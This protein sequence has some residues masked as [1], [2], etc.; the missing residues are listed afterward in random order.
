[1]RYVFKILALSSEPSNAISYISKAFG[2]VGEDNATYS[3][4]YN[5]INVLDDI[6][7]LELNVITDVINTDFDETIASID[8]IIYFLN[9]LRKGEADFFE[10]ILPIIYSVKRDI[11]TIIVI[12]DE[13]CFLPVSINT[14]LENIWINYP[15]LEAF[16]NIL[17]SEFQQVLECLC[18]AMITGDTP[19]NIENAWMRFP[20][21]IKLAN[22][23][24]QNQNLFYAAQALKKMAL[25]ANIYEKQEYFI[26]SEQAAY[27][28][29]KLNLFLEAS[30]ILE[31]IDGKKSKDFKKMYADAI[32]REG[33]ILFN[34]NKFE[35]AALQYESAGQWASIEL[36]DKAI[37][38]KS[39]KLAINSWIS[40]CK[41]EKSFLILERLPHEEIKPI[42]TDIVDKIIA[43]AD[44]LMS[45]ENFNSARE[46]LYYSVNTY[47][48][49]GLS[50]TVKKLTQKLTIVLTTI[51]KNSIKNKEIYHAKSIYD[52]IENMWESFKVETIDL[53]SSL[54]VLIKLF[55]DELNFSM[56]TILINKLNSYELKKE[57][58]EYSSKVEDDNKEL[59]KKEVE[60][61][62]QK[63]IEILKEFI[64]AE[65]EIVAEM[66]KE[67]I[68]QA[69]VLV[70]QKDWLQA[71]DHIKTQA[72]F[73]K[74]I[75]KE[76]IENQILTKSLDILLDGKVFDPFFNYYQSL[77]VEMKNNYLTRSYPVIIEKLKDLKDSESYE[78][79]KSVFQN[80]NVIFRDLE[81]YEY[82][83]N[84]SE[85]YVD[86]IKKEIIRIV[87]SEENL[88]GVNKAVDLIKNISQISSSY[89]DN[90][91]I[92]LDEIYG[93]ITEL[94][95]YQIGDL[96]SAYAYNDKIEEK[97]LKAELHK[98]IVDIETSQSAI[99]VAAAKDSLR[100]EILVEKLS[101]IKQKARDAL[102]DKESELKQR[103]GYKRV[104]F[105]EA[106]EFIKN[107]EFEKAVEKYK[108]S[109]TRLNKIKKY[110]LAGVSLAITCLLLM[111]E[112]KLQE[113]VALLKDKDL[114]SSEKSFFDTFP[115]TLIKYIMDIQKLQDDLKL[116]QALS[117]LENLPLF[118]EE[119]EE[120]YD[121]LGKEYQKEDKS[122][123]STKD[124][125]DIEKIIGRINEI[126]RV[127]QKEKSDVSKRKLMKKQY[128]DEALNGLSQK[129]MMNASLAYLNAVPPLADKNLY[130]HAAIGLILGSLALVKEKDVEIS[131]QTFEN[132]LNDLNQDKRDKLKALPEVKLM[133]QAYLALVSKESG[134]IELS[135]N[136]LADKL[137]L[138]D[139]EINF[140]KSFLEEESDEKEQKEALSRRERAELS[141]HV[142]EL[143]QTFGTL[144]QK[145]RDEDS[146][147]FFTKRKAMRR[148]YYDE[149]LNLLN[150]NSFN[151]AG[152]KYLELAT[153]ISKRKDFKTSS[154]LVLL[155]GLSAMKAGIPFTEIESNINGFLDS[156]G[157]NKTV[158][159]D[160]FEIMLILF[161]IDIKMNDLDQFTSKIVKILEILPFFDEEKELIEI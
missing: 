152:E 8:G 161:I 86:V 103:R 88:T 89:L 46:Q 76:E 25:I 14:L 90:A 135:L 34:K 142:V 114:V 52:E 104:Y 127:I 116:N 144:E 146:K 136:H 95:L 24:F 85:L 30:K 45:I 153:T 62:I 122:K 124:I 40:A 118:E 21:F 158:V 137:I 38:N 61:N 130:K 39:F 141:K 105:K 102:H 106:L 111:K 140:L 20:V 31:N 47:Q 128:W 22:N 155:Y 75:G 108:E 93:K 125:V 82:S 15:D 107:G 33:N 151:K 121:Y 41:C 67:K 74:E 134:L 69:D 35:M 6:C 72:E 92:D 109:I 18:I 117:F 28:Y 113:M 99:A 98:K 70:K 66:N 49:E 1:M 5:E 11:P 132:N 68:K 23:Y 17:P 65:Q 156:L 44:Y 148:H 32:I 87:E 36:K 150:N 27:L 94:Y 51:F 9:P 81:L 37:I 58:T 139:P 160:T 97:T 77:T 159:K 29:A 115:V 96:S 59:L 120:L 133:E 71:A 12:Y 64:N 110:N 78:N 143:D 3:E 126:G 145:L 55:L 53:D 54:E 157:L 131:K 57:L 19:L 123:K 84:I 4:W 50:E 80:F 101:I 63:G 154:F 91:R 147:K 149:V 112:S 73:L 79:S 138:F 129:S 42:L 7:D 60:S 26:F 56:A 10:M 16:V 48:R 100:E 83:K 2:E 119:M 13:M 43:A